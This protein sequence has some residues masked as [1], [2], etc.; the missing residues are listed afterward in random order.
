MWIK[1][2]I[3]NLRKKNNKQTQTWLINKIFVT[4][5][6]W[7]LWVFANPQ[8]FFKY[9]T[10]FNSIDQYFLIEQKFVTS[11]LD[12]FPIAMKFLNPPD[13]FIKSISSL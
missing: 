8:L 3:N 9:V 10:V 12:T 11:V 13:I 4:E 7:S 6:D 2:N 1:R 5:E